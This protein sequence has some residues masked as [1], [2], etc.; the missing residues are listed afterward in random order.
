[1][2]IQTAIVF[3][4]WRKVRL[5]VLSDDQPGI[6]AIQPELPGVFIGGC[7]TDL[8]FH[9]RVQAPGDMGALQPVFQRIATAAVDGKA[10]CDCWYVEKIQH[11]ADGEAA[12]G[13][14]EYLSEGA[15]QRMRTR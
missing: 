15:H 11:L 10:A 7:R 12:F 13:Q 14:V 5:S 8:G 3:R 4:V 2:A 6:Q 9:C 1:M